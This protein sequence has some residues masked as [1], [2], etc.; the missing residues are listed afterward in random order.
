MS[1]VIDI[2]TLITRNQG[3]HGGCPII[4]G[5]GVTVRRIATDYKMGLSA[6]EIAAE[7]GHLTLV[8]IYAA[9]AYYH[10][11]KNEIETDLASQKAEADRLEEETP[12]HPLLQ[13]AG[14]LSNEEA[15]QMQSVI[16]QE[17]E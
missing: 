9:M 14:I 15:Q 2:G 6:E 8:Q 11:N 12:F 3:I 10:A 7:I 16:A 5:T 1:T 17:F 13:F 4:A